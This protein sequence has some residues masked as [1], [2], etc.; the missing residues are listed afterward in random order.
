M[1]IVEAYIKFK[2]G[3]IILVSGLS[4][5]GKNDVAR[6]IERD[7]KLT[8]LNLDDYCKEDY[9]NTVE[10]ADK[11]VITDWDNIDAYDWER[12]NEDVNKLKKKGLVITGTYFTTNSLKFKPDVHVHIKI[13]KEDLLKRR[14]KHINTSK[15]NTNV[16]TYFNTPTYTLI[17]NKLTLPQY[18][19]SIKKSNITKF[20][21]ISE[22]TVE[23]LYDEIGDFLI[24][25]IH[26]KV[27]KKK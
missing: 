6:E 17:L 3:L 26:N 7:F 27:Y 20:F 22:K 5:C 19:D 25:F 10:L 4:G 9:A 15:C 24:E 11:T 13:T 12:F 18:Y 21:N 8:K 1:N 14:A 16:R 2:K 23:Q